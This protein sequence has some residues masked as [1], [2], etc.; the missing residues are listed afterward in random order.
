MVNS[1]QS[2]DRLWSDQSL[3][4][5]AQIAHQNSVFLEW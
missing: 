1:L 3:I 4:E 2:L 5:I